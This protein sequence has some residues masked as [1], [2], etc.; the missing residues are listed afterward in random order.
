MKGDRPGPV[1]ACG[2]VRVD[3]A[4]NY[5]APSLPAT[6]MPPAPCR[7]CPVCACHAWCRVAEPVP[8]E[9]LTAVGGGGR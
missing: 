2:A 3:G 5:V 6:D 7:L 8:R 4:A 1:V 9:L